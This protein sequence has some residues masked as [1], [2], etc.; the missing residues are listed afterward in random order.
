LES[1][2][3]QI[4]GIAGEINRLETNV[5][6]LQTGF[7]NLTQEVYGLYSMIQVLSSA[8]VPGSRATA[9]ASAS[10]TGSGSPDEYGSGSARV[11]T[12]PE[13]A[14]GLMVVEAVAMILF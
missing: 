1:G 11:K 4:N 8:R 14:L 6:D 7:T 9:T 10:A 13:A 12:V 2:T 5:T 3:A